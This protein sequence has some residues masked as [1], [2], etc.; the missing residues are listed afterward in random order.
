M[1]WAPKMPNKEGDDEYIAALKYQWNNQILTWKELMPKR[2]LFLQSYRVWGS[3]LSMISYDFISLLLLLASPMIC[4]HLLHTQ[5]KTTGTTA[6]QS[7]H[8]PP[9][10]TLTKT[11][12]KCTCTELRSSGIEVMLTRTVLRIWCK[13]TLTTI[14]TTANL[15]VL[16]MFFWWSGVSPW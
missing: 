12:L 16:R 8:T 6:P 5:L 10:S 1:S 2:S 9:L 13:A 7:S 3:R 15:G 14:H 4:F 11:T